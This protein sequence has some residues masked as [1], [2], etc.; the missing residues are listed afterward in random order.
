VVPGSSVADI[1]DLGRG[2]DVVNAGLGDD[3][4]NGGAGADIIVGGPATNGKLAATTIALVGYGS[5][6]GDV[7]AQAR[8]WS[9]ASQFQDCWNSSRQWTLRVTRSS[10]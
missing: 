2:N 6:V 3:V 4:I 10:R 9:T 8:F 5:V 7:G 1:I